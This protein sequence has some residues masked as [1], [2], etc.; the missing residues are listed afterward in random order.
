MRKL[1][2]FLCFIGTILFLSS[3]SE[4]DVE[5][6]VEMTIYEETG[7]G[8]HPF[9]DDVFD[10][11]LLVSDSDDEEKS[12]LINGKF[13]HDNLEYKKGY[14]YK[15]KVRKIFL[16]NPPLDASS[17]KF[18]F[19]KRLSKKKIITQNSEQQIEMEVAPIKT[20]FIPILEKE[21]QQALLVKENGEHNVKPLIGIEGFNY[22]EGYQ[23]KLSVKKMIEAEPYSV[24]YILLA[25]VSKE[26]A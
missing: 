21:I 12:Y 8:M 14:E 26:E 11:F 6:I 16:K 20:G 1:N 25:I 13:I 9:S 17:I 22:E 10:E 15:V 18:E 2:L 7:Y 24:K 3:C 19:I 4:G 23:Y 5:K